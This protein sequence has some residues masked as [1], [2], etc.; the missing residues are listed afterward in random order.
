VVIVIHC[1]TAS[2]PQVWDSG[3]S[4]L[5]ADATIATNE[6]FQPLYAAAEQNQS[7][8][9]RL[10]LNVVDP[11]NAIKHP[12]GFSPF[13][14]AAKMDSKVALEIL[15]EDGRLDING[16]S[17]DGRTPLYFAANH[18]AHRAVEI[19]LESGADTTI[20]SNEGFHPLYVAA[21][22]N[23]SDSLRLLLD[24]V[25]PRQSIKNPG[26]FSPLHVAA[27]RNS[28]KAMQTLL[29]D[30]R[31]AINGLSDEGCTPLYYGA[32]NGSHRTVELLLSRGADAS[33]ANKFL[34]FFASQPARRPTNNC[35]R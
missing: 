19:F 16:R 1:L 25:D 33:I 24:V 22:G 23:H 11:R 15:L 27:E 30:G 2:P 5:N 8:S 9:L 26:G 6:G 14:T 4:K 34:F 29:D 32:R 7:D 12:G 20:A 3:R 13:H 21:Q 10:L 18:G 17:D 31:L 35:R 28:A